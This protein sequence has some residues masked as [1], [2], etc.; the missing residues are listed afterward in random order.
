MDHSE[1]QWRRRGPRRECRRVRPA[2]VPGGRDGRRAGCAK[3]IAGAVQSLLDPR[4]CCRA[5][6]DSAPKPSN[7]LSQSSGRRVVVEGRLGG[8]DGPREFRSV[9]R[10]RCAARPRPR[11][12]RER[13]S[14]DA[15][16]ARA[17]STASATPCVQGGPCPHNRVCARVAARA[18][19]D[20]S[21]RALSAVAAPATI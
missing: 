4:S 17:R 21:A 10:E 3:H 6:R 15:P 20:A 9:E 12:T 13:W 19:S 7:A 2:A 8:P 11:A 18:S 16:A 14:H 5:R 1:A